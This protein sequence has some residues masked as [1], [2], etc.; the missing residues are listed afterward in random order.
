MSAPVLTEATVRKIIR[1]ANPFAPIAR[2][3]NKALTNSNT[4]YEQLV[5]RAQTIVAN[6]EVLN[7][8]ANLKVRLNKVPYKQKD[9]GY[10]ALLDIAVIDLNVDIQRLLETPH[11]AKHIIELFDPRIMQPVNVI[12]IKE[13]G[14]YSAW[15]GQQSGT[16]FAIMLH[17][18]LIDPNTQIQ[19]KI[20]DND[21]VVPGSTLV[22]EAVGNYGFRCINGDGRMSPDQ[23][24]IHRSMVNGV[25]L[26]DSTLRD[27]IQS[28]RIQLVLEQNNM[29]PAPK[30]DATGKKALPGM[31]SHISSINNTAHHGES[32]ELFAVGLADLQWALNWHNTFFPNEKGVDGG[33][34]FTFGRLAAAA[35][36]QSIPLTNATDVDLARHVTANYGS[37]AGFHKDCKSRLTKWQENNYLTKSWQDACL[38]PTLI[39][40]YNSAGGT[41]TLPVI[42]TMVNYAGI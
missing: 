14:R 16:A 22:G 7:A 36:A 30:C 13:T 28:N 19:A 27:D 12:Y 41:C 25:R 6:E 35:R 26:Y 39:S 31:I 32:E 8:I 29:F 42:K 37:P 5:K 15:E 1:G 24:Y 9:F 3:R 40:D 34:I 20:V 33:F 2:A 17:F 21:L 23:Y 38:L 4:K 11:I 10:L 18:G